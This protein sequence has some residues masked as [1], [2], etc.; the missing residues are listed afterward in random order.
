MSDQTQDAK[1]LSIKVA[2]YC[3]WTSIGIDQLDTLIRWQ[4]TE[5][6]DISS[7]SFD[8]IFELFLLAFIVSKISSCRK[9]ARWVYT[10]IMFLG[11]LLVLLLDTSFLGLEL[12]TIFAEE[13]RALNGW[14][15]TLVIVLTT[16][17]L[18]AL[19]LLF[20][21]D[22]RKWFKLYGL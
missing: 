16:L 12:S 8:N 11:L 7:F 4:F 6:A 2:L 21:R 1:P 19:F 13:I 9:W 10:A 20:V 14:D 5:D 22:S 17:Q 15:I 3:L 18:A